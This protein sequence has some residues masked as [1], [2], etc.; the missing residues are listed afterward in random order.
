MPENLTAAQPPSHKQSKC[1]VSSR[2]L[3]R[4]PHPYHRHRTEIA[5]DPER[6]SLNT[7][8]T[9]SLLRSTQNTD[10]EEQDFS[11]IP[12][13]MLRGPADSDSGTE[14]DDEHFLKGLP[15]PKLRPHK[16]LRGVEGVWSNTPSPLLSPALL[17][18]DLKTIPLDA[19]RDSK[20]TAPLT[21]DDVWKAAERFRQKRRKE[22][23]RRATEGAILIFVGAILGLN[24]E[25]KQLLKLW[26]TGKLPS[27]SILDSI[28]G[29]RIDL[30]DSYYNILS[31]AV[32]NPNTMAHT[33]YATMEKSTPFEHASSL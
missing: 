22:I 29:C 25:V 17:D 30:P 12:Y 5:N 1:D 7:L 8:P 28:N 33:T 19:W 31:R 23:A 11:S 16:G 27:P 21:E 24:Q 15:A 10:D 4:S 2:R 6:F 13:A 18:E 14:A 20:T 9:H 3:S 26:K 32:S